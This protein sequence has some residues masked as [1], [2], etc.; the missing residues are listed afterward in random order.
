MLI[1]KEKKTFMLI[2]GKPEIDG[3]AEE[4]FRLEKILNFV[5]VVRWELGC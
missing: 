4:R 5:D 1:W 3:L 2:L